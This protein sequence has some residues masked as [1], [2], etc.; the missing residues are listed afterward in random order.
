MPTKG[1]QYGKTIK[2][3]ERRIAWLNSKREPHNRAI[4]AEL[5]AL[6]VAVRCVKIVQEQVA[7]AFHQNN[8]DSVK[9][10]P[11]DRYEVDGVP[12]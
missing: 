12:F 8:V 2:E 7:A 5:R 10:P 3:L 6:H 11:D 4:K 1:E 9:S